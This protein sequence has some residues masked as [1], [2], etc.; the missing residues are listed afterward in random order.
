MEIHKFASRTLLEDFVNDHAG[1]PW[2]AVYK[3]KEFGKDGKYA[4]WYN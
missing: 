3:N 4:D 1:G 2:V